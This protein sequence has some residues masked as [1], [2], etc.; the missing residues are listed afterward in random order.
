MAKETIDKI[1]KEVSQF[2]TD[3]L[4][5]KISQ[6]EF[7]QQL[8]KAENS[9]LTL[10]KAVQ[11]QLK[12]SDKQLKRLKR[13]KRNAII[14]AYLKIKLLMV[15]KYTLLTL[16]YLFRYT[17]ALP[18]IA[19]IHYLYLKFIC[20]NFTTLAFYAGLIGSATVYYIFEIVHYLKARRSKKNPLQ[21]NAKE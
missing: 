21:T 20:D 4:D 11:V 6:E 8:L 14:I 13:L 2:A 12:E 7:D 18:I 17:I 9:Y 16:L 10:R 19:L 15:L 3:Y 1:D 5:G